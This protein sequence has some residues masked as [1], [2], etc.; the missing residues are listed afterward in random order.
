LHQRINDIK[1][2]KYP[3]WQFSC[4]ECSLYF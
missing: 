4:D 1:E 3:R 2:I